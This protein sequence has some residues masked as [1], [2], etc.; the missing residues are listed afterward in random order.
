MTVCS[1][2]GGQEFSSRRVLWPE[3]IAQ[4]ELRPEEVD[5]ID[6]Q[7]GTSCTRCGANLRSIALAKA[8]L[9][10]LHGKPPLSDYVQSPAAR[11]IR[12]L[13]VNEAGSLSAVLR[14]LPQHTIARYPEHDMLG[15]RFADG[16]FDVVVHS[17]TLEHVQDPIRGLAQC[18]RVL[19]PGGALCFT[20]PT[21]VGR[22]TRGRGS[23]PP[24]FHGDPTI[25]SHDLMV[26]TE[27]GADAWAVLMQA[28]FT[29]LAVT[30]IEFPAAIAWTA[31]RDGE[32]L[33]LA[34]DRNA[35]ARLAAEVVQL[36]AQLAEQ[37]DMLNALRLSTSWRATAPIRGAA[38]LLRR[39]VSAGGG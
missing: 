4:W 24:S 38:T 31:W 5:Y 27:F 28:G 39:L 32:R 19:A 1:V 17:D 22:L 18:R 35:M 2:C 3:L 33:A 36:N 21:V 12:M 25:S 37:A 10:A 7:Q 13:E 23:L 8:L 29:D 34:A 15:L 6:R 9:L 16:A 11:G 26:H 14:Q 30:C 20:V